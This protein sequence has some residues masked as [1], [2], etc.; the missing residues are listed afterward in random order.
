[1][2]IEIF[3]VMIEIQRSI[4]QHTM[5]VMQHH[6]KLFLYDDEILLQHMIY[7]IQ[8]LFKYSS[9]DLVYKK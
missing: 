2:I 3:N 4:L 9:Y 5:Y 8:H 7:V 6:F 1:M